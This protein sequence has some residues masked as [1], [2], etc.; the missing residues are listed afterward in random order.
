MLAKINAQGNDIR[1]PKVAHAAKLPK[2]G[3]FERTQLRTDYGLLVFDRTPPSQYRTVLLQL[4]AKAE[5]L[6]RK[7]LV[8]SGH[9]DDEMYTARRL[10]RLT[11]RQPPDIG[12]Q[13]PRCGSAQQA[14]ERQR[15]LH[16]RGA[17]VAGGPLHRRELCL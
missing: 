7:E 11:R 16:E 1:R 13:E 6:R 14:D 3:A 17:L 5:R 4:I 12:S 8:V 2:V 15:S 10:Q 9:D